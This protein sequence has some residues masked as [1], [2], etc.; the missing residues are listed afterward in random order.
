MRGNK[1]AYTE[2]LRET[3]RAEYTDEIEARDGIVQQDPSEYLSLI[4]PEVG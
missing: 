3:G 1:E 2:R 4:G